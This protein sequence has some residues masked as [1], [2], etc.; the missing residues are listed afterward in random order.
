MELLWPGFLI[1]LGI[2]PLLIAFYIL[3]L[4]RR[5]RYTVRFSS[6]TLVRTALPRYSRLR[7]HLPFAIFLM[8]LASLIIAL[9]RP[10]TI[11][12]IPTDQTTIIFA[13]DVSGSM[14]STDIQPSRLGAA[15]AAV[16]S[17][18]QQQKATTQI[19]LVAFSNFGEII[20]TPTT[21][22]EALQ[23]ALES[24]TTGRRTAVGDGILT[25]IDA[26]SQIDSNVPASVDSPTSSAEPAPVPHGDYAP[27]IIVLLSDGQSNAGI[28]PL[29][30]AQEAADRGI[31]IYTIGYGTP[32]GSLPFGGGGQQQFQGGGGGGAFGGGGGGFGGGGGG[33]RVGIDD[34]VLKQIAA[35]TDGSYH[36]AGSADELNS[37]FQNLPTYLIT[38]HEISEVSFLFAAI[39]AVLAVIAITLSLLWH[40]LP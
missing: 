3:M 14:R 2:I 27:D 16:V 23:A 40:S 24:L 34:V 30:A 17:F 37:V 21:D 32:N 22:Q 26:I 35:L 6:L 15:E 20:Q 31:R 11:I 1:L 18:I 19:G 9:G 10:V 4:R 12:S 7:R 38:K 33:F 5:R 25:A 28:A 8:A 36:A 39:G 29:D 13:L